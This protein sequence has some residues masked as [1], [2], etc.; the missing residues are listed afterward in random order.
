M[1]I[2]IGYGGLMQVQRLVR[3]P[4]RGSLKSFRDRFPGLLRQARMRCTALSTS[5][6]AAVTGPDP[7]CRIRVSGLFGHPVKTKQ[8]MTL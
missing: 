1:A 2:E 7:A 4:S 3:V 8:P 6:A 5:V